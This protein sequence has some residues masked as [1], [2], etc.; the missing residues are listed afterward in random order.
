MS[1][2]GPH[3]S[4]EGVLA[5]KV[6]FLGPTLTPGTPFDWNYT[7]AAQTGLDGRSFPY[8]RGKMLG[9]CSSVSELNIPA[10]GSSLAEL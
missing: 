9:G 3:Y 8:P 10:R 5:A 6:P 2:R 4:D 7:V 1:N